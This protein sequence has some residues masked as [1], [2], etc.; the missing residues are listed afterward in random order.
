[1]SYDGVSLIPRA[2]DEGMIIL[3]FS[4]V[5]SGAANA[6]TATVYGA[7][8]RG[9]VVTY[10]SAGLYTFVL[11]DKPYAVLGGSCVVSGVG[12]EDITCQVDATAA[13]TTGVITLKF[14]TGSV[15]TAPA[16]TNVVLGTLIVTHT[17]RRRT[18]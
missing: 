8:I 10:V 1:M 13:G 6:A 18:L 7:C 11:N 17:D 4:F 12:A 2:R 14:K 9:R 16:D 15:T 3:P 5:V